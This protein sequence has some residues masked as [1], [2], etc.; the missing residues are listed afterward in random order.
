MADPI[1][2]KEIIEKNKDKNFIQRLMNPEKYPRIERPDLGSEAYSTH[3]MSYS[4][5]GDKYI[6]FPE[7]V[8]NPETKTLKRFGDLKKAVDYALKTGEYI[9]FD[10]EEDADWFSSNYK[11]YWNQEIESSQQTF[12]NYRNFQGIP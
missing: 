12:E 7:I 9:P 2:L 6:V 3:L 5:V 11:K 4:R 1:N 10:K 8:Y